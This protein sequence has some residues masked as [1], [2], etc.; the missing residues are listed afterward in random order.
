MK[1][2]LRP[3]Y[4][5][6]DG[7]TLGTEWGDVYELDAIDTIAARPTGDAAEMRFSEQL[8]SGGVDWREAFPL[9]AGAW[10]SIDDGELR[11]ASKVQFRIAPG[12]SASTLEFRM[13]CKGGV[14]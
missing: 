12:G 9:A 5:A 10:T 4:L 8:S 2:K 3:N 14:R 7:V 11:W 1:D 13:F 6:R